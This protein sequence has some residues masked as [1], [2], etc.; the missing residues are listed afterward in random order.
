MKERSKVRVS[1]D[2][3]LLEEVK[4]RKKNDLHIELPKNDGIDCEKFETTSD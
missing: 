3:S 2:F 1:G 4:A